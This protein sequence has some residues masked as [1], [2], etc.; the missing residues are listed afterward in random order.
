MGAAVL[1]DGVQRSVERSDRIGVFLDG[2]L[3]LRAGKPLD[4]TF[5]CGDGFGIGS[6]LGLDLINLA[7]RLGS[8]GVNLLLVLCLEAGQL[9]ADAIQLGCLGFICSA[10]LGDQ[11]VLASF[12]TTRCLRHC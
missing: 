3:A 8:D 10:H 12:N 1:L 6:C 2:L 7:L 9:G 11:L 4:A 5:F